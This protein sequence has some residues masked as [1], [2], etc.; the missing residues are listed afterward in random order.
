MADNDKKPSD[1]QTQR[2]S[3][4]T[5]MVEVQFQRG[6]RM[7]VDA[8]AGSPCAFRSEEDAFSL[9][10]LNAYLVEKGCMEAQLFDESPDIAE[11]EHLA[12]TEGIEAPQPSGLY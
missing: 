4:F 5:N 3:G 6:T 9:D 12:L 8:A 1:E 7:R 11:T 2:V 10:G